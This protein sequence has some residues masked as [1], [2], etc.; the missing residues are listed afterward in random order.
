[1]SCNVDRCLAQSTNT[2]Y[3]FSNRC[4]FYLDF[5]AIIIN[6]IIIIITDEYYNVFVVYAWTIIVVVFRL[7]VAL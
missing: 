2:L 6:I 4:R 1:M 5:I 3:L 7:Y